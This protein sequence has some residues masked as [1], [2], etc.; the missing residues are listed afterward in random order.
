MVLSIINTCV[1]NN[2]TKNL[3][4]VDAYLLCMLISIVATTLQ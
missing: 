1:M 3:R 2:C 4:I